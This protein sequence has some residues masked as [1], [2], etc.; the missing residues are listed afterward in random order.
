MSAT[1]STIGN[2]EPNSFVRRGPN[3]CVKSW[4]DLSVEAI[5]RSY[6]PSACWQSTLSSLKTPSELISL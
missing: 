3:K 4:W 5:I 6:R 2:G 1:A